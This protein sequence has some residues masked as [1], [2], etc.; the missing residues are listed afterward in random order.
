V[1]RPAKSLVQHVRTAS[2][3]AR[4]HA[5]L[6][7]GPELEQWPGLAAL[8]RQYRAAVGGEKS[9]IALED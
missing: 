2:F 3:R 4:R 1:A 7:A 6:L 5:D 9:A 8:Q